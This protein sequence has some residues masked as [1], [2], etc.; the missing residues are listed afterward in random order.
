MGFTS[1]E[2]A[3]GLKARCLKQRR[4]LLHRCDR[5][6]ITW[7]QGRHILA[8]HVNRLG[9]T[10]GGQTKRSARVSLAVPGQTDPPS[11]RRVPRQDGLNPRRIGEQNRATTSERQTNPADAALLSLLGE[12]HN[13]N[14]LKGALIPPVLFQ[15]ALQSIAI[16]SKELGQKFSAGEV[17]RRDTVLG[18]ETCSFVPGERV[19][20]FF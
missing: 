16:I 2:P 12:A 18:E 15:R 13:I 20:G 4:G 10:E 11:A 1:G 3:A 9:L 19:T 8:R 17:W 5:L 14:L 7:H 6:I